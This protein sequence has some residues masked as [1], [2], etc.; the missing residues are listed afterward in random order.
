MTT[1][2]TKEMT[3]TRY[4]ALL[5]TLVLV[6]AICGC[7]T[8]KPVPPQEQSVRIDVQTFLISTS[9]IGEVAKGEILTAGG[10]E[11]LRKSGDASLVT[12]EIITARVGQEAV[13]RGVT[14]YTYPTEFTEA[15]TKE[16]T[17]TVKVNV[18]VQ[19]TTV[20]PSSFATREV[21]DILTVA[22]VY[23]DRNRVC[24][25]ISR[26][27]VQPP[28]WVSYPNGNMKPEISTNPA[29]CSQP[30]FRV[31][32]TEAEIVVSPGHPI[33]LSAH[34]QP[35]TEHKTIVTVLMVNLVD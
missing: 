25:K 21:G 22:P 27:T 16:S 33:V 28:M 5:T 17:P 3:M 18:E 4:L 9:D 7:R 2:M 1:K 11:R 14:E 35:N 32:A 15:D 12:T 30:V 31:A 29:A 8:V 20:T 24:L 19:E 34:P 10:I 23:R 13:I 6:V 26:Q